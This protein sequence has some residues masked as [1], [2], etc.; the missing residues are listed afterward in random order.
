MRPG[1]QLVTCPTDSGYRARIFLPIGSLALLEGTA[2]DPYGRDPSLPKRALCVFFLSGDAHESMSVTSVSDDA[3]LAVRSLDDEWGERRKVL[4]KGGDSE[5]LGFGDFVVRAS[6]LLLPFRLT[7]HATT[8]E[9]AC[10]EDPMLST[11]VYQ[12]VHFSDRCGACEGCVHGGNCFDSTP[13]PPSPFLAPSPP[14]VPRLSF[15]LTFLENDGQIACISVQLVKGQP[16]LMRWADGGMSVVFTYGGSDAL[17]LLCL[18]DSPVV[19]H[20]RREGGTSRV[21]PR[22]SQSKI[23]PDTILELQPGFKCELR[24]VAI[25]WAPRDTGG[26][27]QAPRRQDTNPPKKDGRRRCGACEGC[28][29]GGKCLI[30]QAKWKRIKE[31]KEEERR[32]RREERGGGSSSEASENEGPD[33]PEEVAAAEKDHANTRLCAAGLP[34]LAHFRGVVCSI[35]LRNQRAGIIERTRAMKRKLLR[36][37]AIDF[38]IGGNVGVGG[39]NEKATIAK[40]TFDGTRA[41]DEPLSFLANAAIEEVSTKITRYGDEDFPIELD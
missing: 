10:D 22:N 31:Q 25:D 24:D 30:I 14:W 38:S 36:D 7:T 15:D 2:L 34:G 21:V 40:S 20:D 16:R 4:A 32:R 3:R 6:F 18:G 33:D 11:W 13:L 9:F 1:L 12:Y 39:E 27:V 28:I 37:F 8:Q 29:H 26:G 35:E 41:D 5:V 17:W 19:L 23:S